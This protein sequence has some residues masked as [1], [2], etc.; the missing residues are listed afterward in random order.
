MS[1]YALFYHV[2][3]DYVARRTAFRD[4]HLQLAREAQRRGELVL[5]GALSDPIDQALLVFRAPDRSVVEAFVRSDPYVANSLVTRWEIRLWAVA[6][7]GE[8]DEAR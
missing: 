1:Y 4:E 3:E 6:V 2:V 8:P 5:G 7:G